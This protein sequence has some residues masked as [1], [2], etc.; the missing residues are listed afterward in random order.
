MNK[1]NNDYYHVTSNNQIVSLIKTQPQWVI[2]LFS[3]TLWFHL[4]ESRV[5]SIFT[6]ITEGLRTRVNTRE[7]LTDKIIYDI[8]MNEIKRG[9]LDENNKVQN[10]NK[11]K[12]DYDLN[13]RS[14]SR[15]KDINIFYHPQVIINP[16][17]LDLGGGDGSITSSLGKHLGL[18][19]NCI[20][21]ADI[22]TWYD[23]PNKKYDITYI[24]LDES[25]NLPFDDEEFSLVTCFQS[26]HHMKNL[27]SRLKDISRIIKKGGTLII[28][29][30]DCDSN[31]MRMLI[32]IEHCIFELVLKA[33]TKEQKKKE[34][35]EEGKENT[36][37]FAN[38]YYGD[39]KGKH[40]W[41]SILRK[42]GF[43]YINTKYPQR[44]G[45]YN[46]TRFYYAMYVKV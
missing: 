16:K 37:D 35:T 14:N 6:D 10:E 39:Y 13:T 38:N 2:N 31:D 42:L 27:D 8:F 44:F 11:E 36:E 43:K 40:E 21:C 29:E 20:V 24:T 32:D 1:T 4:S 45:K 3:K 46:P 28:R 9:K 25:K 22:D 12:S 5:K 18:P 26:L 33:D 15:V 34:N 7:G 17:Y 30:H 41:S 23:T 19:C